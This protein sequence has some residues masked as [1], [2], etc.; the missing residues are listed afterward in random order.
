M[1]FNQ[2]IGVQFVAYG[3]NV[4]SFMSSLNGQ[5]TNTGRVAAQSQR[6][7][8]IFNRTLTAIRTTAR[9]AFAGSIVFGAVNAVRGLAQFQSQ[10]GDI[11]S[12][13]NT[14]EGQ[15][16]RLG[17]RLLTFSTQTATPVGDLQ[18]SVRNIVSTM[19]QLEPEQLTTFAKLFSQ[20]ARVAE[21]DAYN[22]GNTVMGMRNAF[23]LSTKDMQGIANEFVQTITDSAGTTGDEWAKFS[24][25]LVAGA[26]NAG[27][28]LEEMNAMFVLMSRQGGTAATNI[29]HL[30]QLLM[31]IR[32]PGAG[33][34]KFWD[35]LG[36]TKTAMSHMNGVQILERVFQ[37]IRQKGGI[38]KMGTMTE[39]QLLALEQGEGRTGITGPAS[40][41]LSNMVGRMESRRALA[42]L[43]NQWNNPDPRNPGFRGEVVRQQRS[44]RGEQGVRDIQTVEQAFD[45]W[46]KRNQMQQ[47]ALA[48][49]NLS[50]VMLN[51]FTPAFSA[52]SRSITK[53]S[54]WLGGEGGKQIHDFVGGM[55]D[56]IPGSIKGRAGL[57]GA[58]AGVGGLA[59]LLLSRRLRGVART[60]LG[61]ALT[62]EA[63]PN[64]VAGIANG[65]RAAPFW[66][67]IH[68]ESQLFGGGG[69]GGGFGPGR[70]TGTSGKPGWASRF[71][72]WAKGGIGAALGA[73]GRGGKVGRAALG[74]EGLFLTLAAMTQG[75]K[76]GV[77]GY[78]IGRDDPVLTAGIFGTGWGGLN[79]MMRF[80]D[81]SG[82]ATQSMLQNREH[83]EMKRHGHAI[84][85]QRANQAKLTFE[86][87]ADARRIL[88]LFDVTLQTPDG[89]VA[90]PTKKWATPPPKSRGKPPKMG[91]GG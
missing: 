75:S 31:N 80:T 67:V 78:D 70:P 24:G 86:A 34:Q 37:A 8:G 52:M 65:T 20:G 76:W 40:I 74:A 69:F 27:V 44:F 9:Y 21:T 59:A 43:F 13:L 62:A 26:S 81:G 3:G 79:R 17:D 83:I 25:R 53:F 57:I 29:R 35:Q 5:L 84:E 71:G 89:R 2:R 15:I 58:G 7:L 63:L 11:N 91:R 64:A 47:A 49:S 19:G 46:L 54:L 87:N 77:P 10:L 73:V 88:Q 61:A 45:R 33:H 85:R 55:V 18:D 42:V 56:R 60:G 38:G 23:N 82:R 6:Q 90:I 28:S 14:T 66:V 41:L 39:D 30:S 4:N 22:F 16:D 50:T 1:G 68:P 48:V 51:N 32:N 12:V 72:S 36:L